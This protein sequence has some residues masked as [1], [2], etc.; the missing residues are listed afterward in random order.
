[1]RLKVCCAF[2]VTGVVGLAIYHLLVAVPQVVETQDKTVVETQDE[3]VEAAIKQLQS[4]EERQAAKEQL[5][6][7]GPRAVK[8]LILL[9]EDLTRHPDFRY[10]PGKSE[11]DLTRLQERLNKIPEDA[12]EERAEAIRLIS[13][14]DISQRLKEDVC[15]LLGRL[16]AEEAIPVLIEAMEAEMG[17]GQWERMS[18]AMYALI[19]IGEP[20]VPKLLEAMET[21]RDRVIAMCAADKDPPS[22]FFIRTET[23]KNQARAAMVLERIGDERAL[24]VL[25]R[26]KSTT[27]SEWLIPYLERSI[28]GCKKRHRPN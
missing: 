23:V 18:P 12:M 25:E 5:L 17:I 19:E 26:I 10:P 6:R 13:S 16:H 11:V 1:M 20:A 27:E 8:S 14:L 15:E 22:D 21:A 24:P 28:Q 7:L 4:A 2:I 3:T 9:L